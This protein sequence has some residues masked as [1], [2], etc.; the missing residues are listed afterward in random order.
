MAR[1]ASD[2]AYYL[3]IES[4]AYSNLSYLLIIIKGQVL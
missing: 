1:G 3:L 2:F 4:R